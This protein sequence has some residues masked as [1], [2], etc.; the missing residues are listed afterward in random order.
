MASSSIRSAVDCILHEFCKYDEDR[1]RWFQEK[2]HFEQ[3]IN[4]YK[5]ELED[6]DKEYNLLL[7][8][9][10]VLEAS[11]KNNRIPAYKNADSLGDNGFVESKANIKFKVRLK[12]KNKQTWSSTLPTSISPLQIKNFLNDFSGKW[13]NKQNGVHKEAE[14]EEKQKETK[15]ETKSEAAAKPSKQIENSFKLQLSASITLRHHLDCVR[16][17][18]L[19]DDESVLVSGSDDGTIKL[20]DLSKISLNALQKQKCIPITFRGHSSSV[21]ALTVVPNTNTLISAGFD[22]NLFGWRLP[23]NG[24]VLMEMESLSS[25][26]LFEMSQHSDIIWDISANYSSAMIASVSSDNSLKITNTETQQLLTSH[27]IPKKYISPTSVQWNN[28]KQQ[29]LCISTVSGHVIVFDAEKQVIVSDILDKNQSAYCVNRIYSDDDLNSSRIYAACD[30]SRVR[31]FDI[32]SNECIISQKVHTDSVTSMIVHS[33]SSSILTSSHDSRLRVWD[34]KSSKFSC[35]QDLEPQDT[36]PSK[37]E[38]GILCMA[39]NNKYKWLFSGGADGVRIYE[40]N[41]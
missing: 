31:V 23:S 11:I 18:C 26:R 19:N 36:H 33:A 25:L 21:S 39:F 29:K 10:K 24:S 2:V 17:L 8:R 22:G 4:A 16:S 38:E 35:I 3:T 34:F 15:I 37:W 40:S 14:Y 13:S 28:F 9:Y 1:E 32:K 27:S 6:K 30:D 12:T 5:K 7:K 41:L 20:W